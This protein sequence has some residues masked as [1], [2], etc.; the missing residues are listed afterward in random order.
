LEKSVVF[1][2]D[3]IQGGN[4]SPL[5]SNIYLTRF[6]RLLEERGHR[7]VRYADD[8]NI[9]LK[10]R[11]AAERVMENSI[12]F[13]EGKRMELR[14]NRAKSRVGSPVKLKFLGF[15]LYTRSNGTKGVRIHPKTVKRFKAKVKEITKR[16]RGR[17]FDLLSLN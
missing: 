12:E 2:G 4:L 7:F 3:I 11:R 9:Y 15:A 6:A 10:S 1:Y 5:L 13:L 14:V 16:N 17:S 8:C